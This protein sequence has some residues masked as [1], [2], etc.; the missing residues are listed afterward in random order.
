[1][2]NACTT[3]SLSIRDIPEDVH[4]ELVSRAALRGQS[5]QE[6]LRGHLVQLARRPDPEA[7]LAGVQ[8][9][10][11][12]TQTRLPAERILGYRDSERR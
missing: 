12:S 9:R 11:R 10:K 4:A 7:L 5:L 1:M 8:E 6:Y 2:Q 3:V